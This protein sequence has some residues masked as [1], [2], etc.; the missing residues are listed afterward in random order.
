L[1]PENV[2]LDPDAEAHRLYGATAGSHYLLRPD[3]YVAY[4]ARQAAADV[5][6]DYLTTVLKPARVPAEC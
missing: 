5:L 3:G 1:A 4:R 6:Q 2:F